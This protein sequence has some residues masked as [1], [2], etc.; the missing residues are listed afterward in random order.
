MKKPTPIFNAML[1]SWLREEARASVSLDV[2]GRIQT[3]QGREC[4][5]CKRVTNAV[6]V[7]CQ[8]C[9]EEETGE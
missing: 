4:H 7:A 8:H 2:G 6:V 3:Q 1:R 9:G 5:A